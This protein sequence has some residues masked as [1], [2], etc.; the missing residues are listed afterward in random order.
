M[1]QQRPLS[2]YQSLWLFAMFDLPTDTKEA[3]ADYRAFRKELLR[4]GFTRLQYSVYARF[5]G[6][7]ESC[8]PHRARIQSHMPPDG[9]VRLLCVTDHQFGKMEVYYGK[10]RAPT[11][12]PPSQLLLF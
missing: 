6:S 3:R 2:E 9:Q 7:E 11:E 5:F 4:E 10:T 8:Q 12:K 1:P